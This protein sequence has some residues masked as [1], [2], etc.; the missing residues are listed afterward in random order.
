[1]LLQLG[2]DLSLHSLNEKLP[3]FIHPNPGTFTAAFQLY[4]TAQTISY[5]N[6]QAI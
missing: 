6:I 4:I 1:M 5:I 2:V 3:I